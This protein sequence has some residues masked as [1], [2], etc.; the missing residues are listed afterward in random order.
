MIEQL[1]R[2]ETGH[3]LQ[4]P[5]GVKVDLTPE[6]KPKRGIII[7]VPPRT[8]FPVSPSKQRGVRRSSLLFPW[9]W[10]FLLALF[11]R[12]IYIQQ[13]TAN[14]LFGVPLVDAA[15]Y[16]NWADTMA[17]GH[18]LWTGVGNYTPVY[19]AF[20]AVQKIAFGENDWFNRILQSL[21]GSGTAVLTGVLTARLWGRRAGVIAGILFATDW[22]FI[23]YDSEKYAESFCLFFQALALLTLIRRHPNALHVITGGLA[24]ALAAGARANLALILPVAAFWMIWNERRTFWRA[25]VHAG[26][27]TV[28][29]TSILGPVLFWNHH[30]TGRWILREQTGWNLYA[31]VE[32]TF[33]GISHP[34]PG[35]SFEK[36]M[37]QPIRE[38]LRF[39][40]DIEQFWKH[41]AL[42]IMRERPQ[43]VLYGQFQRTMAFLNARQWSQEFDVNV[44]R[45]WSWWLALPCWPEWWLIGPLGI[46]GAF[47]FTRRGKQLRSALSLF[48]VI[49]TISILL[50]K[51]SGRYRMPV[52]ALL[53]PFA[54][55]M[56]D[57]IIIA[58]KDTRWRWLAQSGLLLSALAA[59][60]W[61]DW[62]HIASKQVART[63]FFLGV[64]ELQLNHP[65]TA[66]TA[67]RRS[68]RDFPWDADSPFRAAAILQKQGNLD[69]AAVLLQQAIEREPEFPDALLALARI[70][71]DRCQFHDAEELTTRSLTLQPNHIPSLLLKAGLRRKTGNT[72]E[73]LAFYERALNEGADASVAIE[74]ALRLDELGRFPDAREILGNITDDGRADRFDRARALMLSGY[75][76]QRRLKNGSQARVA[77]EAA[78]LRF[79]DQEFFAPQGRFLSGGCTREE[80][81][82]AL[83]K[84]PAQA[85]RD[86]FEYNVG[87]RAI[88]EG[89][90]D[91]AMESY[92]RCLGATADRATAPDALPQKWAW[93]DLHALQTSAP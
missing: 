32:P 91:E 62:T 92:Q 44:W 80:Y 63:D 77:W 89:H 24:L 49:G 54:G 27:F 13:S 60:C 48:L 47:M 16:E 88:T 40:Q 42:V 74:Y 58:T 41:K 28:A 84:S 22:M 51:A 11:M 46:V 9:G 66:L 71:Y 50:F 19:P 12:V 7:N 83:E 86:F 73:E 64:H 17:R 90:P 59:L 36:Y 4:S 61:P 2:F 21:M 52:T 56:V 35:I 68:M 81:E 1:S 75:I 23:L 6:E 72:D 78:A 38:G 31:A 8:S 93:E 76:A 69:E 82:R 14:P 37:Q 15:M 29:A 53:I 5:I 30:L 57:H 87:L 18:W 39:T 65:E 25:I 3:A 26:L 34:P 55:A 10:I 45:A 79:P 70:H 43:A 33:K 20:L 67:F 85:P